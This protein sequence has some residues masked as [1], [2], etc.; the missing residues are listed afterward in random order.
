MTGMV[1]PRIASAVVIFAASLAGANDSEFFET[2]IRPLLATNCYACHTKGA[3]GGL[4]L[5]SR[6]SILKGGNSGKA[7]VE[8]K[9]DESLLIQAVRRTH[10]RLKMPPV[11]PLAKEDVGALEVW[12]RRGLPWP[13]KQEQIAVASAS[14]I[15][16]EQ[17]A[18]WSFQPLKRSEPPNVR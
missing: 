10:I 15:T 1:A 3:L 13:E 12:V 4:R 18:F 7:V 5:D 6:D 8:G 17:R 9:P 16:P 11:G 14:D 2:R